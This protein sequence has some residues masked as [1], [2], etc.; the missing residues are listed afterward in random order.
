MVEKGKA[1]KSGAHRLLG[2][3]ALISLL[4]LG[5]YLLYLLPYQDLPVWV[6]RLGDWVAGLGWAGPWIFGIATALL[7]GI[8]VPRLLMTGVAAALFGFFLGL[9]V[10]LLGTLAGAYLTFALARW[11]GREVSL[12]R[13]SGLNRFSGLF[14]DQGFLFVLLVR[15]LPVSSFYNNLLLGLTAVNNRDFFLGSLV[16]LL[17]SAIPAALIGAGLIQGDIGILLKYLLAALALMVSLALLSRWLF[18]SPAARSIRYKIGLAA[19][20]GDA[21]A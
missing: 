5:A 18:R 6:A 9:V 20:R 3:I 7:T 4:L 16:G 12:E 8:G 1:G 13:W 10:S 21:S 2:S 11:S 17:P 19:T 15:Q 14:Q